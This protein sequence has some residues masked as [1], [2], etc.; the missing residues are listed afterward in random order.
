M[1]HE[2][3][4]KL[5]AWVDGELPGAEARR[6]ADHVARNPEMA[7]LATAMR[8][9]KG[10]L[11]GNELP[12]ALPESR[13]FF[14]SKIERD[15][16]RQS[17]PVRAPAPT[18]AAW[19]RWVSPLL[20]FAG[21]ACILFMAVRPYS[22]PAFDEISAMGEGMEAVTFNDQ[23]AGMTVV[24]LSDTTQQTQATET[25]APAQVTPATQ[26]TPDSSDSDMQVD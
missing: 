11:A 22:Q 3:E 14:W 4:M 8:S 7:E 12:V 15:I 18:Q 9:V 5:Q 20:G 23:A 16:E 26:Q 1:N 19:R 10:A 6:V 21:L 24:W 17:R 2:L 13:E 25:P